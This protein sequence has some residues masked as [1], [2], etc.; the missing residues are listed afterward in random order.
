MSS[1]QQIEQ[2]V[3]HWVIGSMIC[4][5]PVIL[6]GRTLVPTFSYGL[7]D[8]SEVGA[9]GY[10]W[11]Y[12]AGQGIPGS[13]GDAIFELRGYSA[14][15][16]WIDTFS[17]RATSQLSEAQAGARDTTRNYPVEIND[18]FSILMPAYADGNPIVGFEAE[19]TRVGREFILMGRLFPSDFTFVIHRGPFP[20][21]L[22]WPFGPQESLGKPFPQNRR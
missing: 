14:S 17:Q 19:L 2:P 8:L 22:Q 20:Q 3:D 1:A 6:D 18:T 10:L 21:W 9:T 16:L 4:R 11:S 5:L 12:D 13:W 15:L 7:W